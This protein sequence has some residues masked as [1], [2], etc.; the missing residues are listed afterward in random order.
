MGIALQ[1]LVDAG[2]K[3]GSRRRPGVIHCR[4]NRISVNGGS[5]SSIGSPYDGARGVG[6]QVARMAGPAEQLAHTILGKGGNG[7]VLAIVRAVAIQMGNDDGLG[8]V[9]IRQRQFHRRRR[10]WIQARYGRKAGFTP[11]LRQCHSRLLVGAQHARK[12]TVFRVGV[13]GAHRAKP[14][15]FGE[16]VAMPPR[17]LVGQVLNVVNEQVSAIVTR[18]TQVAHNVIEQQMA[19]VIQ[20]FGVPR[21]IVRLN[22]AV[23]RKLLR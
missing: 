11:G 20:P 14:E 18:R 8:L 10:V 22:V 19:G 13:S 12:E 9:S 17:H 1:S 15:L 7:A 23:P 2:G 3:V 4:P 21:H 6:K 5:P 16:L